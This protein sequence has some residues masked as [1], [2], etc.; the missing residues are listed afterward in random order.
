M[1][2]DE[3]EA[4]RHVRYEP[5]ERAP[6]L[7]AAGMAAQTVILVLTGIMITP[8]VIARGAGLSEQDTSWLVFGALLA[9]QLLDWL[10]PKGGRRDR[11]Q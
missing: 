8:L 7:L 5:D 3:N 10:G 2:V 11:G 4:K 6:H 1:A 9:E